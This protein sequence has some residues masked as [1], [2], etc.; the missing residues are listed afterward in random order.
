MSAVEEYRNYVRQFGMTDYDIR[1]DAAIAELEAENKRLKP[2]PGHHCYWTD[3]GERQAQRAENAE[4]EL[5]EFQSRHAG[6]GC[7]CDEGPR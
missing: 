2:G 6:G 4:A 3:Y 7:G 5:R 1:A